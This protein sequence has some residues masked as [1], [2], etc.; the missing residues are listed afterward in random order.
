[1]SER[2]CYIKLYGQSNW[3]DV[4]HYS[5]SIKVKMSK[6]AYKDML[7]TSEDSHE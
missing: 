4:P 1:M 6:S 7:K 3:L 2:D 5:V